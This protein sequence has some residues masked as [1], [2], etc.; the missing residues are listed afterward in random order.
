MAIDLPGGLEVLFR[1]PL[2]APSGGG[3][4]APTR[5]ALG[6]SAP[7]PAEEPGGSGLLVDEVA[8]GGGELLGSLEGQHVTHVGER[9]DGGILEQ[10]LP[11][12]GIARVDVAVGLT[13]SDQGGRRHPVETLR[14]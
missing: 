7:T 6:H 3:F 13:P 8:D 14:D 10:C 9:D 4:A 12:G 5:F 1:I 11:G 2:S